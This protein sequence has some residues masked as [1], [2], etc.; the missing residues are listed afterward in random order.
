[1]SNAMKSRSVLLLFAA[2]E[3]A[4]EDAGMSVVARLARWRG[5]RAEL[6]FFE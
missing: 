4:Q 6:V 5:K 1:M 3:K 2:L